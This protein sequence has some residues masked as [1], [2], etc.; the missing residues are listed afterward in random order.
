MIWS[1]VSAKLGWQRVRGP[2]PQTFEPCVDV[3][4]EGHIGYLTG[5]VKWVCNGTVP[6]EVRWDI[7]SESN[8]VVESGQDLE[9]IRRDLMPDTYRLRAVVGNESLFMSDSVLVKTEPLPRPTITRLNASALN[10]SA[11]VAIVDVQW[12]TDELFKSAP[13]ETRTSQQSPA[14]ISVS[15]RLADAQVY[16]RVSE[17]DANSWSVPTKAW[18]TTKMCE[19]NTCGTPQY[20]DEASDDPSDWTCLLYTSPSPRDS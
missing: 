1:D 15:G 4:A 3:A 10:V 6:T 17:P 12:S 20:L 2:P 16:V 9:N 11:S 7:L 13:V 18:T 19:S 5:S 14:V 8:V